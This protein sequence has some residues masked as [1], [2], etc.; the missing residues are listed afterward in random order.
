MRSLILDLMSPGPVSPL[1]FAEPEEPDE[2]RPDV[3]EVL[4]LVNAED[5]A[6][7]SDELILGI[8]DGGYGDPA[9]QC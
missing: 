9:L 3:S 7:S 2:D 4:M 6:D 5:N 1:P 8:V